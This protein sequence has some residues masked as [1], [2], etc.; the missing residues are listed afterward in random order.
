MKELLKVLKTEE[1]LLILMSG[2]FDL[3]ALMPMLPAFIAPYLNEIFE[4]FSRV[5]AWRYQHVQ[6]LPGSIIHKN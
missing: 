6:A 3:L 5:A 1:D 2:L 4:V